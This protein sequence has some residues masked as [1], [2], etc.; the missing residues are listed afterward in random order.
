[1]A[2]VHPFPLKV[3]HRLYFETDAIKDQGTSKQIRSRIL[4]GGFV[5]AIFCAF[6]FALT[7]ILIFILRSPFRRRVVLVFRF[8]F[9]QPSCGLHAYKYNGTYIYGLGK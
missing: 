9:H 6:P 3:E 8:A 5:C 4:A 1:M 2:A 7:C